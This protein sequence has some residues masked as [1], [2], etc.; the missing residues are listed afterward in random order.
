MPF[1]ASVK[2]SEV[3][4][5][6]PVHDELSALRA[7][8]RPSPVGRKDDRP[9]EQH[10]DQSAPPAETA[11]S[12]VLEEQLAELGRVLSDYADSAEEIVA[13]HPLVLTGAAF[14][15]GVAVGYLMKRD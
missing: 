14:L 6:R 1:I 13:K 3:P 4:R 8:L 9:V 11:S 12:N 7:E 5:P 10:A 2:R 15:L